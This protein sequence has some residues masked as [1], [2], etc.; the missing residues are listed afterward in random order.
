M[1]KLAESHAW[2]T[3]KTYGEDYDRTWIFD[4]IHH[5]INQ[6]CSS[7]SL[8]E[9]YIEK[10]DILDESLTK[11]LQADCDK[12]DVGVQIITA[13]VTKPRIP[14]KIRENYEKM[15][16]HKTRLR[17]VEEEAKVVE[18]DETSKSNRAL[19]AAQRE[20]EVAAIEAS[21]MASVARINADRELSI[22]TTKVQQKIAE[23]EGAAKISEIESSMLLKREKALAD[24]RQYGIRSEA[25]AMSLR[26]TPA[27]LRYTLYQSLSN[28][29][30]I[31]YGTSI[32]QSFMPWANRHSSGSNHNY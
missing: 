20:K 8:A 7:H 13:R 15:E 6:F 17:V 4:K 16:E 22:S 28:N 1:N 29:T 21:Q 2:Q 31:I 27:F 18:R 24:S 12:Y 30:A 9:V 5:E 3:V 25:E 23:K 32:P 14:P 26:L 10:F 19:I 11:A